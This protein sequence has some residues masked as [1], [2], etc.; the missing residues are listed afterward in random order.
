MIGLKVYIAR[1]LQV[2]FAT[3]GE[4]VRSPFSNMMT[5]AVIGIALALPTGLH[6]LL[7]NVQHVTAQWDGAAQISW[8]PYV[9]MP[10]MIGEGLRGAAVLWLQEALLRLGHLEAGITGV[11]DA[12]TMDG[13][14][15]FQRRHRLGADGVAGPLTQMLIYTEL[16]EYDPPRL[17]PEGPG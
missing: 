7:Q 3:L 12:D 16:D 8:R 17:R 4:L 2:F 1:H 11:Y 15:D 9:E 13:V 5:I 10:N 6:V 14:R